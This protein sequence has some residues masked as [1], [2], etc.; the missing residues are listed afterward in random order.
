MITWRRSFGGLHAQAQR[1]VYDR[2]T[3]TTQVDDAQD[4]VRECGSGFAVDQPRISQHRHDVHAKLLI[5][6]TEGMSSR[7]P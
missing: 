5:A 4:I 3:A 2:R 1:Q 7:F 6:D